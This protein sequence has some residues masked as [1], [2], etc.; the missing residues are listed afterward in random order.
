M[1]SALIT[2]D[3]D[4]VKAIGAALQEVG[5]RASRTGR[6]RW[7]LVFRNGR[8][9]TVTVRYGKPW[10]SLDAPLAEGTEE[11]FA[12]WALLGRQAALP[13]GARY[14]LRS[15]PAAH[16]VAES[17][18][19]TEDRM[20]PRIH[21]L[22]RAAQLEAERRHGVTADAPERRETPATVSEEDIASFTL[23]CEETGWACVRRGD[24]GSLAVPLDGLAPNMAATLESD[25]ADGLRLWAPLRAAPEAPDDETSRRA[26]AVLLL[27]V[28]GRTR[29]ARPEIREAEGGAD[30]GFTAPL[31]TP[32][33]VEEVAYALGAIQNACR[34]CFREGGALTDA[35][36]A[37]R[38]LAMRGWPIEEASRR[39][40]KEE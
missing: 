27:T 10:L 33:N 26:L 14:A 34:L 15:G 31:W 37:E 9:H 24:A 16:L 11:G 21:E 28:S 12:P 30:V 4:R 13:R 19:V 7:D 2:R 35:R 17:P 29:L 1:N 36:I 38:Y 40:Q 20:E 3:E 5:G 6:S 32:L 8:L 18:V 22:C 23:L 39:R 25:A